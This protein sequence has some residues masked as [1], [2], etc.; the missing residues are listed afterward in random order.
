MRSSYFPLSAVFRHSSRS[1]LKLA[2]RN[3]TSLRKIIHET[4]SKAL[5]KVV[6]YTDTPSNK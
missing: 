3:L 2:L 6:S 4:A 5:D 1:R